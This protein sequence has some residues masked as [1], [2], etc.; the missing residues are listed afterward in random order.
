[1][2]ADAEIRRQ[3][4]EAQ[5]EYEYDRLAAE[6]AERW[7]EYAADLQ[8]PEIALVRSE[9]QLVA[10]RVAENVRNCPS[11]TCISPSVPDFNNGRSSAERSASPVTS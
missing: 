3:A 10:Q 6:A 8:D 9:S 4:A 5:A 1:M 2:T 11:T 7:R